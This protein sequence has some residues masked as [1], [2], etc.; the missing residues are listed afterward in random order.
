MRQFLGFIRFVNLIVLLPGLGNLIMSST[1]H[2]HLCLYS[3]D[4]IRLVLALSIFLARCVTLG[5]VVGLAGY[6]WLFPGFSL[7]GTSG[8]S[9]RLKI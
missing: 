4:S 8:C 7:L 6:L 5:L 1:T 9:R 2:L 3:L